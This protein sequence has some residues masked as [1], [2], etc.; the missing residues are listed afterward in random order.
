[1][2]EYSAKL[3]VDA[4]IHYTFKNYVDIG[5]WNSYYYQINEVLALTP[6]TVLIVGVGDNIVREILAKQG[7]KVFTF[8]FDEKLHPDF[9]GNVEE[10][11]N[12]LKGK[13]F[14]VIVCFQVLE[15]IPYNQ[16]ENILNQFSKIANNS[17]ISLPYASIEYY[18]SFKL[19]VIKTV[20]IQIRI[21][22][23]YVKHKFNG[24]HY[25]EIGKKGFSK[26]K[27]KK[28]IDKFFDIQKEFCPPHN[29]YHLFFVLKKNNSK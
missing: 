17:I 13:Q 5:R 27:I 25:W 8:D 21:S 6:K 7:L 26:S 20:R 29:S 3:Q 10:I 1:M 24:E 9:L 22:K 11:E 19:P 28:S 14:D 2:T 23:F 16:F 4:D 15:H 12:I 18:L